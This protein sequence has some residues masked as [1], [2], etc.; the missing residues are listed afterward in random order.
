MR[1]ALKEI[2]EEII[3]QYKFHTMA[4]DSWVYMQIEKGVPGVKQAGKIANN[5]LKKHLAKYGY[6]P[7]PR[8]PALWKHATKSTIFTLVV[9]NFGIKYESLQDATHLI[10]AL[11]DLYEITVEW[12]GKLYCGLAMD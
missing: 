10:N 1:M 6:T 2:S 5:R 12:T 9:D 11:K 3:E 7:V 8:T 4:S